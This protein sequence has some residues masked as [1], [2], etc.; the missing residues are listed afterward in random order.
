MQQRDAGACS[1]R[2]VREMTVSLKQLGWG[3]EKHTAGRSSTTHPLKPAAAF[4]RRR[5][6]KSRRVLNPTAAITE[7][8]TKTMTT[9]PMVI[10]YATQT[11]WNSD[12]WW[13]RDTG[14]TGMRAPEQRDKMIVE[15]SMSKSSA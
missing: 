8:T 10:V 7:G 4:Q 13:D 5:Y 11:R 6:T 15:V 12:L 3:S 1:K 2:Y 14:C 9:Q